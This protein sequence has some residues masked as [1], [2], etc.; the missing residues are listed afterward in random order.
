MPPCVRPDIEIKLGLHPYGK[1]IR[2]ESPLSLAGLETNHTCA[3]YLHRYRVVPLV[4]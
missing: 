1:I 4:S 3:L 2:D